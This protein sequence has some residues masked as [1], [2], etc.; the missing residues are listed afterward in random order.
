[1]LYIL[2]YCILHNK[3]YQFRGGILHNVHIYQSLC[4]TLSISYNF[5]CQLQLTLEQYGEFGMPTPM[6][7]KP[8]CDFSQLSTQVTL[9]PQIQNQSQTIQYC[10]KY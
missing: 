7:V 2:K 3:M 4:C 5:I 8:S 10:S 9:H 6:Q 1:M